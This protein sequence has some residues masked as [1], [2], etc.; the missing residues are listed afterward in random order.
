METESPLNAQSTS[1]STPGS[2]ACIN[3]AKVKCK[4]I[5]RTD[6]ATCERCHRLKKQCIVST[7]VG[8]RTAR[9]RGASRTAKLEEKLD[10]LVSRLKT[11][12]D[13][14]NKEKE[15]D[16][17]EVR[18]LGQNEY[19]TRSRSIASSTPATAIQSLGGTT[20]IG[21]GTPPGSSVSYLDEPPPSEAEDLLKKFREE[22][23]GFFPFIYIPPHITSQQLKE[24]YPFLWLNI[25]CIAQASQKERLSL[26]DQAR[27]IVIQKVVVNREKSLDLLLGLIALVGWS[28]RQRRDKPFW[29][30]FSQLIVTLIYDLGLHMP[31][32]EN[33][34]MFCVISKDNDSRISNLFRTP[35]HEV[36]RAVL[37]AFFLTSR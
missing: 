34:P 32:P 6:G 1:S 35:T 31:Q 7:P 19:G 15:N 4:C 8:R 18:E 23:I 24:V 10:E 29:T 37:A 26:G 9:R 11:Q 14:K 13:N 22:T 17:G 5:Y 2:R 20:L 16:L 28:Q 25:M 27:N 3:C 21:A 36:Q 33:P 30:L 12:Q